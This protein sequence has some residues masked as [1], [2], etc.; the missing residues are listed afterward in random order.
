MKEHTGVIVGLVLGLL[1]IVVLHYGASKNAEPEKPIVHHM[2]EGF[3]CITY[4]ETMVCGQSTNTHP[5]QNDTSPDETL[6]VT[7]SIPLVPSYS[8]EF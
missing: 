6:S 5:S 4:R 1:L 2:K 3:I 8:T 7:Y